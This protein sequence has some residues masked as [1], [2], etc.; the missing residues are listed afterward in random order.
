MTYNPKNPTDYELCLTSA[1]YKFRFNQLTDRIEYLNLNTNEFENY[2]D[3]AEAA[4]RL[5]AM[6]NGLSKDTMSEVILVMASNN[7]YHPIKSYLNSLIWDGNQ[8]I[9]KL[10]SYLPDEHGMFPL[11][12]QKWFVGAVKKIFENGTR[13]PVLV[14][15]GAQHIGKST[16]ARK[17]SWSP[18]LVQEGAIRPDSNDHE[19]LL[20]QKVVWEI[21]ELENTTSKSAVGA[22]KDF[23]SRVTVSTRLPY[24]RYPIVKPAITS[25]IG[26][27][28][29]MSGF[30]ND[31]SGS[32]RFR[33]CKILSIDFE[34][35]KID[36]NQCWAQAM[37]LYKSGHT[38]DLHPADQAKATKINESYEVQNPII[39]AIN[40][41]FIVNPDDTFNYLTAFQIRSVLIDKDYG[42]LRGFEFSYQ[43]MASAL[44]KIGCVRKQ[45]KFSNNTVL[46]VYYG[47]RPKQGIYVPNCP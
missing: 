46:S 17:L 26:T 13:N 44:K 39:D 47:I 42:N 5:H 41:F 4:F 12:L 36:I 19:I 22:L 10:A 6:T 37:E 25:F 43:K 38:S 32:S 16:F 1:G 31:D 40:Q 20:T 11:F 29:E 9:E 30:L 18:D 2:S 45:K 28:N 23:L 34:Y 33:V 14:L 8:N 35:N 27:I 7:I 3:S 24:A 15:D 21:G